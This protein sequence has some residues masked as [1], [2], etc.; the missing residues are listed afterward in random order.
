MKKVCLRSG[1]LDI[2]SF[3]LELQSYRHTY[4]FYLITNIFCKVDSI[5]EGQK[6]KTLNLANQHEDAFFFENLPSSKENF[7]VRI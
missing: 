7:Q 6:F 2:T 3:S 4:I 5:G 1:S